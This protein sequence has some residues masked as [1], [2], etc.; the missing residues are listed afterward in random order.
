MEINLYNLEEKIFLNSELQ[1]KLPEFKE[2]FDQWKFSKMVGGMASKLREIEIN[3][4][5]SIE[6]KHIDILSQ[7]FEINVVLKKINDNITKNF[8]FSFDDCEIPIEAKEYREFCI[9]RGKDGF[10]LTLWR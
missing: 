5:N 1:R 10:N 7:Y 9:S 4:I 3:L 2:I 6:Q 8:I